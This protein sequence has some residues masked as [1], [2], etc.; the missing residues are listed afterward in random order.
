VVLAKNVEISRD[1]DRMLMLQ[2]NHALH[3]SVMHRRELLDRAGGYNESLNV[4]I[5]WDLTRKLCFYTDFLH[6]PV[7]T[8]EYYAPVG[9]CDRISV[10]RR[11]NVNEY[12]RNLLTIR[13]TRPPKPWDKMADLAVLLAAQRIDERLEQTLRDLWSHSFYP[14]RIYVPLTKDELEIFK[15]AVPNVVTVVVEQGD[16]IERRVDKMLQRCDAEFAAV[17]PCGINVPV[18]EACFLERSLYPLINGGDGRQVFELVE[19]QPD[20]WGA[21][22]RRELLAQSRRKFGGVGLCEGLAAIGAEIRKP[23]FE[24]YPFLFDHFLSAAQLSENQGDWGQAARIYEYIEQRYGNGFWMQVRRANALYHKGQWNRGS[25]TA[26]AVNCV[27]PTAASLVVQARCLKKMKDFKAAIKLYERAE[28][29][30]EGQSEEWLGKITSMGK[31]SAA[32]RESSEQP[33]AIVWT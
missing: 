5:D 9:D 16:G 30:L 12:L 14:Q 19:S 11:K 21:V 20:C 28:A 22:M 7:I 1:F 23:A 33:E 29:I 24:E 31:E 6:V 4:L 8:G 2:F 13:T 3:V 26:E 32:A 27:R 25:E 10:Q 15:T 17:V 18:E